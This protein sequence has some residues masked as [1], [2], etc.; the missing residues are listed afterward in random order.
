MH[1]VSVLNCN[2]FFF[3]CVILVALFAAPAK[4][5]AAQQGA[6]L[7]EAKWHL[8]CELFQMLLEERGA[9]NMQS[10]EYSL[11]TPSNSVIVLTDDLSRFRR[12]FWARLVIFVGRGGSVLIASDQP[13][14]MSGIGEIKQ[15]P[16][17]SARNGDLYLQ[18]KDCLRIQRLD[19]EHPMM[20]GVQ[21]IIS[22]KT[23]WL[24]L[25]S[26]TSARN[27]IRWQTVASL[28]LSSFPI[29]CRDEPLIS[30][31]DYPG[32][33]V[34]GVMVLVADTSILTNG[35]LWHGDNAALAIRLSEALCRGT[36][37]NLTF[38]SSGR[39]LSSY[40]ERLRSP[41]PNLS[42][43]E[44]PLPRTP[45][46]QN[47]DLDTALQVANQVLKGVENSN[48]LNEALANQPR[49]VNPRRYTLSVLTILTAI[50]TLLL[51]AAI[52]QRVPSLQGRQPVVPHQ[53]VFQ[54]ESNL[55]NRHAQYGPAAFILAREFCRECSGSS[56][57]K[58]W[59]NKA[60]GFH[61]SVA[62]PTD[63]AFQE[64]LEYV[65]SFEISNLV[66]RVSEKEFLKLG[67]TIQELR[68][69]LQS[70]KIVGPT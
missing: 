57:E 18:H 3:V 68:E 22:N 49:P 50:G 17:T 61:Y 5:L 24:A 39:E 64:K 62:I 30:V 53:S 12:D 35:M 56:G 37:K 70:P 42:S 38:V 52:V 34:A 1:G 43:N 58:D 46:M 13:C 11:S 66:P 27:P 69:A 32:T 16:V 65:R 41:K 25:P 15:G 23:A 47:L 59:C 2:L 48:I 10:L 6:A 19:T 26:S 55:K 21:Q 29:E 20:L 4:N 54:M 60:T 44:Q 14:L 36:K 51:L 67:K 63:K 9:T 33:T 40:K 8:G 31:G 45:E 7:D 28:P